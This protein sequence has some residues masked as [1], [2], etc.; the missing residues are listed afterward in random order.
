MHLFDAKEHLRKYDNPAD[1]IEEY[2]SIRLAFYDKRK[3]YQINTL[4]KEL[5]IISNKTRFINDNLNGNI[6]LRRKKKDEIHE[7]LINK[8]YDL[9]GNGSDVTN[10]NYLIKMPMDSVSE[11]AVEKLMKEKSERDAELEILS[12]TTIEEMWLHELSELKNAYTKLL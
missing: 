9:L 5:I 7:I 8:K 11:E 2:Y 1:I 12:Q 3:K 10:F 6:D 4:E